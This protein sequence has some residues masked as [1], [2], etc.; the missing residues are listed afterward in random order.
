MLF[1]ELSR[2]VDF[3][4]S[5]PSIGKKIRN[6]AEFLKNL[7]ENEIAVVVRLL[8][9]RPFPWYYPKINIKKSWLNADAHEGTQQH[10]SENKEV[11]IEKIKETLDSLIKSPVKTKKMLIKSLF[12][13]LRENEIKNLTKILSQSGVIPKKVLV[14]AIALAF[15]ADKDSVRKHAAITGDLGS[16]AFKALKKSLGDNIIEIFKPVRLERPGKKLEIQKMMYSDFE[17]TI[18][19]HNPKGIRVQIHYDK[20]T[21]AALIF[22]KTKGDVTKKF[23]ELAN[24]FKESCVVSR[25]IVEAIISSLKKDIDEKEIW[26]KGTQK[27]LHLQDIFLVDAK[28]LVNENVSR[29]YEFLKNSFAKKPEIFIAEKKKLKNYGELEMFYNNFD[30]SLVARNANSEYNFGKSSEDYI[31]IV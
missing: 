16:T 10:L 15:N 17:N 21:K 2:F 30:K 5:T 1:S 26:K 12:L 6:C 24:A 7:D 27:I 18:F 3:N 13:N 14:P 31:E 11:N 28:P 23:K 20:K 9:G 25:V 19:E 4:E 29:R 22:E 8:N